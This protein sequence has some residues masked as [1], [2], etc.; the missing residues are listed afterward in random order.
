MSQLSQPTI[1]LHEALIRL[2][3]GMISAWERWLEAKKA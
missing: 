3:R 1:T 2:A